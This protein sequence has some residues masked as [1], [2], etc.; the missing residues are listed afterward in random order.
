MGVQILEDYS[1]A[2]VAYT[3]DTVTLTCSYTLQ[4]YRGHCFSYMFLYTSGIQGRLL[5]LHVPIHFRYTRETITHLPIHFRYTGDTVTLTCSYTLQVY[6]GDYYTCSYT[7][8]EYRGHCY[9]QSL[10]RLIILSIYTGCS[11]RY[12]IK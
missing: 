2:T 8:Q 10:Y 9:T 4:V 6:K 12:E 11:L 5:L 3:G 7:L 1:T